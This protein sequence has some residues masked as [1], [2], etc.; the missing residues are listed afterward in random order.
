VEVVGG[1]ALEQAGGVAA[2]VAVGD[3]AGDV[4]AR[5][6]VVLAAVRDVRVWG[7]VGLAVAAA[8]EPVPR[9]LSAGG[10][11]WCDAG[12]AG[13]GGFGARPAWV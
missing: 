8:A 4:V 10:G 3:P 12:E 13:E 11:D 7:A 9:R 1:V 6:G 2:A 5:R